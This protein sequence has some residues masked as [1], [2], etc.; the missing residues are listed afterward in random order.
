MQKWDEYTQRF[1]FQSPSTLWKITRTL[2]VSHLSCICLS[3]Q[4]QIW[5]RMSEHS[6]RTFLYHTLQVP[7]MFKGPPGQVCL[8]GGVSI[9]SGSL[10]LGEMVF[11]VHLH[12]HVHCCLFLSAIAG[13][14]RQLVTPSCTQQE[15]HCLFLLLR[16]RRYIWLTNRD[17]LAPGKIKT[18]GRTDE[19]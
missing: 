9:C 6:G 5:P 1:I 2:F 3:T 10:Q 4:P 7:T 18:G 8:G 17:S 19:G 15:Q 14:F 11:V 16:T 13:S 12:C